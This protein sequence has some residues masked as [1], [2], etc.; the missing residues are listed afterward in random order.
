MSYLHGHVLGRH[1]S[2]GVILTELHYHGPTQAPLHRHKLAFFRLLLGGGCTELRGPERIEYSPLTVLFH[3]AG[4]EHQD[5]IG[6]GGAHFF[7]IE[8]R[9]T[10][11]GRLGQHRLSSMVDRYGGDLLWLSIQLYRE[12]TGLPRP[13]ARFAMEGFA[14]EL[15]AA[16]ARCD[17]AGGRSAG[18]RWFQRVLSRLH[19]ELSLDITLN[20]LATSAG[21]HPV[22]L[23][24]VFQKFTGRT[25][26]QYLQRLRVKFA[27]Q[28]LYE[29]AAELSDVAAAAGFSDQ[30][31]FTHV[32]REVSGMTPGVFRNLLPAPNTAYAPPPRHKEP[33]IYPFTRAFHPNPELVAED[34]R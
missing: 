33:Q 31:H 14:L 21:V 15:L 24:R 26:G 25:F 12:Y 7:T 13:F 27:C 22:H 10:L 17:K 9:D 2:G 32:F 16:A 29:P 23:S 8:L 5:D 34:P 28:K 6:P 19:D 18:P 1:R 20:T 11:M 30:S 4:V 3:P